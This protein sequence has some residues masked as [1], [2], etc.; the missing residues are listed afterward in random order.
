MA[1]RRNPDRMRFLMDL[2]RATEA[3]VCEALER[4]KGR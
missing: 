2:Q 4:A 1:D 3:D